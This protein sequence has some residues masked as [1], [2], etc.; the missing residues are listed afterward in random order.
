MKRICLWL[1]ATAA[2]LASCQNNKENGGG[3]GLFEMG[4]PYVSRN[5]A[6]EADWASQKKITLVTSYKMEND[7][8]IV[9]TTEVPLPWSM[10]LAPLQWLPN[11]TAENMVVKDAADWDLVLNLTGINEKPGEHFFGLYNRYLGILRIFYYLTEDRIPPHD[12]NDHMWSLGVSKDLI[13]H[14]NFQFAIPYGESLTEAYKTAMGGDDAQ[15]R[16]TALT[17]ACS[18]QGK[19]VPAIGWWA[20]DVD[21]SPLRNHD[22]FASERSSVKPGMMVSAED[23]VVL[24]SLMHGS[25][26]G[27]F[28][29]NMNLNSLKGG[30]TSAGGII[31]GV[32][33]SSLGGFFTNTKLLDLFGKGFFSCSQ[34]WIAMAGLAISGIGKGLEAGLKNGVTDSDKLGDFNGKINLSLDASIETVGT[35]GGARTSLVPSPTLPIGSYLRS[36]T[37][38]GHPT[39]LGEGVWN[40][41]HYP[42]VYVV[43]DVYWG[44]KAN[45]SCV[46]TTTCDGRR[47]YRLTVDP[48][49]VGLRYV[50]FLDPTSIGDVK[51]NPHI[52]PQNPKVVEVSTSY[53]VYNAAEPGYTQGFR[54]AVGLD[55][56]NP[57]ISSKDVFQS[58][59][60]GIGFRIIKKPHGDGLFLGAIDN[61]VKDIIGNRLSQQKLSANISRRMVGPSMFYC[62]KD[63]DLNTVDDVAM[64][65]D[66]AVFL[67]ANSKDRLLFDTDIPDYVVSL[68]LRI[69]SEG[70]T[71]SPDD[72]EVMFHTLR[73]IPKVVFVT[74]AEAK[75]KYQE[76]LA[77][78]QS[79]QSGKFFTSPHMTGQVEHIQSIVDQL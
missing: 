10:D 5:A 25:L 74:A 79:Y 30:G 4:G 23:N 66:P 26:N 43:K 47:A 31:A 69:A 16:T 67:P 22:F 60:A 76:I 61:D 54:K 78:S 42:V 51:V 46:G 20:F 7:R 59:D 34:P 36:E 58:N 40:I 1:L 8:P 57:K 27:T 55:Y 77:R 18:D 49:Q 70:L 52:M 39:C 44:D 73:F 62:K 45:F 24:N 9:T 19:V 12:G 38:D 68:S 64:V 41:E 11:N 53:G 50:S 63:A 3:S 15:F 71:D 13:E 35:I 65:S 33:G 17:A 14:I 48:D 32:L 72:D 2:L 28:G 21:M 37:P 29:G 6:F 56:E 75:Q